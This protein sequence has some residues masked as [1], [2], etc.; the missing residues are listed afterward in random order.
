MLTSALD[1]PGAGSSLLAVAAD[2]SLRAWLHIH[3]YPPEFGGHG[4]QVQRSLPWLEAE[5]IRTRV[6]TVELPPALAC[7]SP[8]DPAV[9]RLLARGSGP[10]PTL[11]RAARLRS[12]LRRT[13]PR[14]D[15]FHSIHPRFEVLAN[16]PLMDRL[17]IAF[18]FEATLLG[19]N[20]PS[21][22]ARARLGGLRL[23]LLRRADAWI[24][25]SHAFE[26]RFAEAGM[27]VERC[28]VVPGGVDSSRYRPLHGE[29][30]LAT[31]RALDL[32]ADA[33]IAVSA[34]SL[35]PRKGMDRVVRAWARCAP[36]SGRDLLLLVGPSSAEDRLTPADLEHVEALRRSITELEV[37]DSVRLVGRVDNLEDYLGASDVFVF[38]SRQEGQGYV[39]VEA[40]ACGLP[41][42]VSP[43]DGIASEMVDSGA[44]GWI[45]PD[46]DDADAVAATLR[47]L[48][49]DDSVRGRWGTAAR[50]TALERFSM[51]ARAARLAEIYRRVVAERHHERPGRSSAI[52]PETS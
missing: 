40:M 44:S 18:V 2:R 45:T 19:A 34:G 11:R 29:E 46:A 9:D 1:P 16:L 31:R 24:G 35:V 17:G 37:A 27:A 28:H 30:R 41:I 39:I 48:L 14:L 33:R 42:I 26:S 50:G 52:L 32:P 49:D 15:V 4:I 36:R 8:A 3:H 23:R 5:G 25:L 22:A 20:D 12:C 38:L 13:P 51:E 6:L 47:R 7:S 21:A 10:W 43:L